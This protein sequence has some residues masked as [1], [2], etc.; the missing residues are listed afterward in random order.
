MN[1]LLLFLAVVVGY[2]IALI[3]NKKKQNFLPILL[4]FS[5]AFLLSITIFELLPEVFTKN[6]DTVGVYIILGILLQI[7]LEF[8]SKGAEHG[9]VHLHPHKAV[10]P[11]LLFISLSIHA[12]FEGFPVSD[13]NNLLIGII[14]HKIPIALILTLFFIKA[15]YNRA[16]IIVFLLF[17]ALMSPIGTLLAHSEI[18]FFNSY[19]LEITALTIGILFHVSSTI[20]F[21]SSI[22]QRC[23]PYSSE[24]FWHISFKDLNELISSVIRGNLRPMHLNPT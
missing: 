12:L 22:F 15:N 23:V 16:L 13:Q 5:G 24:W 9:H 14:V 17:F 7:I 6:V 4:A 18:P 3:V 2:G 1:Y 10:F 8:F 19:R 20:L 21:E 11:W